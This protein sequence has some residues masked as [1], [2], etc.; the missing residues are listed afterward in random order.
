MGVSFIVGRFIGYKR[1]ASVFGILLGVARVLGVGVFSISLVG[2]VRIL[3]L[4]CFF[5]FCIL[6][7]R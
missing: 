1:E 5:L 2:V 6:G 3:R 7:G 4:F